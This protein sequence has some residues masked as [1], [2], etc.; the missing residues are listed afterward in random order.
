MGKGKN[1]SSD[2]IIAQQSPSI[3]AV[4]EQ[5]QVRKDNLQTLHS[6]SYL[7]LSA[8]PNNANGP[9]FPVELDWEGEGRREKYPVYHKVK[10]I[11]IVTADLI[12]SI[13][14]A[15]LA[16]ERCTEIN[17]NKRRRCEALVIF[18]NYICPEIVV[19]SYI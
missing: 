13:C 4:L 12:R 8:H 19:H 15:D 3:A 1:V 18:D 17:C 16:S 2:P 5:A 9:F 11:G 6:P 7:Q 14:P 10:R